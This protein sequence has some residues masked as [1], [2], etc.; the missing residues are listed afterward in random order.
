VRIRLIWLSTETSGGLL[1]TA[2]W[3]LGSIKVENFLGS[4]VTISF[5]RTVKQNQW[6][7]TIFHYKD[8]LK[9]ITEWN[10]IKMQKQR[11][12]YRTKQ[13]QCFWFYQWQ[14]FDFAW[15]KGKQSCH[16][17]VINVLQ[18]KTRNNLQLDRGQCWYRLNFEAFSNWFRDPIHHQLI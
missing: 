15:H 14:N 16:L 10:K 1:W 3:T 12:N 9:E 11:E 2:Q 18:K 8:M 6:W 5:S 4:W 17:S 13:F 7:Y